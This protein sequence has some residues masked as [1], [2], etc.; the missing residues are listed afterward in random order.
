MVV[1]YFIESQ[2]AIRILLFITSVLSIFISGYYYDKIK[3]NRSFLEFFR[4]FLMIY[5]K[6]SLKNTFDKKGINI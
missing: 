3:Y 6:R 1:N 4:N 5:W 2:R